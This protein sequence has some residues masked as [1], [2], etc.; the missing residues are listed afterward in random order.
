MKFEGR[1]R[2]RAHAGRPPARGR[3]DKNLAKLGVGG[4]GPVHDLSNSCFFP[5]AKI[6]SKRNRPLVVG[7]RQ[8]AAG[9][10]LSGC[11]GASSPLPGAAIRSSD[12]FVCW[13]AG[14][15]AG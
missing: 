7:W 15:L 12:E 8:R 4:P 5:G 2:G 6:L 10:R 11:A 13:S 3:G 14:L 1:R 9:F